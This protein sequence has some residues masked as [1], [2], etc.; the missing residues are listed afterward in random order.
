LPRPPLVLETWGKIRRTKIDGKHVARASYR[1]SDGVTRTLQRTGRTPAEAER[2]LLG[3][4]K[5]R[6][7]PA[8]RDL[9]GESTVGQLAKIWMAET[10]ER[11]LA[12]G[13]VMKYREMIDNHI[14]RGLGSVRLMEANVPRLDRFIKALSASSGPSTAKLTRVVLSGMFSL[15]ARHGAVPANPVRDIATV[16][17][18]K[19]YVV[20]PSPEDVHAINSHLREWDRGKDRRGLARTTDLV[21]VALMLAATGARTGEVLATQW[22]T[23][24]IAGTPA[25]VTL[26]RSIA[27][28]L[29]GKLEMRDRMKSDSS[30]R[31][32]KLPPFAVDMLMQRR[33]HS[34]SELVFPSST[35]TFRSPNNFRTQWRHAFA[36]TEWAG[37]TP[38]AFRKAVAT[39]LAR[40]LGG[41]AAKDQLGHSS[42]DITEEHYI[43]RLHE[44][45]DAAVVLQQFFAKTV[46]KT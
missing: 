42:L 40:E 20:A 36:E 41:E 25:T 22:D 8:G 18:T 46:S 12:A 21:D 44:G 4:L 33:V 39:L 9:T 10:A 24:D 16:P 7:A 43:E 14:T 38:K 26:R 45:P 37:M 30:T 11:D 29:D 23:L 31:R 6:L 28:N 17:R 3:A 27:L 13:T 1:D 2:N 35:G 34:M 15:A 5:E 19:R 32:L